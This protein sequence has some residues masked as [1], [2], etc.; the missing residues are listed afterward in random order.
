MY[1]KALRV[2]LIISVLLFGVPTFSN[3]DLNST[4]EDN[5]RYHFLSW[6]NT[7]EP[8]GW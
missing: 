6:S 7:G 5:S 3:K 8:G 1:Q 2:G 4:F